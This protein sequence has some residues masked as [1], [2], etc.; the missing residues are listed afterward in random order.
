MGDSCL[1]MMEE[2]WDE[3]S[4]TSAESNDESGNQVCSRASGFDPFAW[5]RARFGNSSPIPE[6]PL[7]KATKKQRS[8]TEDDVKSSKTSRKRVGRPC[9]RKRENFREFVDEL[10]H[11]VLDEGPD[12]KLDNVKLPPSIAK[13][14]HTLKKIT[15]I[16]DTFKKDLHRANDLEQ[17]VTPDLHHI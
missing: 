3:E 1:Y 6:S 9:R 4:W 5:R 7:S 2:R 12:F 10:K 13:R 11:K 14:Q 8:Q 16:L 17:S 15:I